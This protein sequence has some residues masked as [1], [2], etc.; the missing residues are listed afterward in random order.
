AADAPAGDAAPADDI[1]GGAAD[2]PAGDAAPA[3]DAPADDIFG[4]AADAPAADDI[5]GGEN[6]ESSD[7]DLF[8]SA[9]PRNTNESV[10]EAKPSAATQTVSV[11]HAAPV[12][13]YADT[14]VR[15]WVDNTGA[16]SVRGRVIL[17]TDAFV[18]LRKSNGRNCTVPM[19]RLSES[20]AQYVQQLRE[21]LQMH[22]PAKVTDTSS[23]LTSR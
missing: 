5:F 18:R 16:Y 22:S 9:I 10:V 23:L 19:N 11:Q 17:I 12:K 4:G 14:T 2:A 6:K 13:S 7:D 20:D 15:N 21:S 3:M 8:N 1:F